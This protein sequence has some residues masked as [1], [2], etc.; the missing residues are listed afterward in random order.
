[1][2]T[3]SKDCPKKAGQ[4]KSP[5]LDN[6]NLVPLI[7]VAKLFSE[8]QMRSAKCDFSFIACLLPRD[9]LSSL[10]PYYHYMPNIGLV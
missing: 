5:G 7:I 2:D 3:W 6:K 10:T 1:M 9:K 8:L 4:R